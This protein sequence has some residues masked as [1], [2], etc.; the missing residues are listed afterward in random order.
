M[1]ILNLGFTKATV[2]LI[3]LGIFLLSSEF[4]SKSGSINHG[5]AGLILTKSSFSTHFIQ[6]SM[7]SLHLRFQFPLGCSDSLIVYCSI[8]ELLIDIRQVSLS[9]SPVAVS[10]FQRVLD[11]SKAFW[12]PPC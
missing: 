2:L 4:I 1:H 11:S 10:L 7:Q 6:V 12:A 3:V 5:L 9:G 8:R